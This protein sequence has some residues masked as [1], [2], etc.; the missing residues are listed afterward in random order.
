M[1]TIH[2]KIMKNFKLVVIIVLS[3]VMT[4]C[5]LLPENAQLRSYRVLVQQ[6][7][8][9][10]E[11]KIDSLK[12]NMTKEQV[13]FLL[14]EPV[15]NNIFNKNRWDYVYYR[16]KYP[17]LTQ[18]NMVS[19]FFKENNV[20][21]MKRISKNNEGLFEINASNNDL[22][23][24]SKNNEVAS[25]NN[26]FDDIELESTKGDEIKNNI[27]DEDESIDYEEQVFSKNKIDKDSD[28]SQQD[29]KTEKS[30]IIKEKIKD[31]KVKEVQL[32]KNIERKSDYEVVK[33]VIDEWK[34]SWENKDIEKYLSFY[35]DDYSS[36]YFNNHELWKNDRKKRIENKSSIEI[37]ITD[38]NITFNIEKNETA[39]IKFI[40]NYKSEEYSD[41]VVKII[42]LIKEN[43]SWKIF[44]EEILKNEY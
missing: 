23:E 18:L 14:G 38:L 20:I 4:G 16:K 9:I 40:Q 34:S 30:E 26:I 43:F 22:P 27:S 39:N 5:Q 10:D 32:A 21:S 11:S 1:E 25:V 42:V 35:I 15:V 37:K 29:E 24:F 12:I 28:I 2:K 3:I 44:S 41:E 36:K 31:I 13:I 19:I 33:S 6:G 17:E 8:V 7:N